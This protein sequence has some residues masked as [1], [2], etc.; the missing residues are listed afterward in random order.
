MASEEGLKKAEEFEQLLTRVATV[1]DE[2]YP[3]TEGF[4]QD[5]TQLLISIK[6]LQTNVAALATMHA[7]FITAAAKLFGPV[8]A[9]A[10]LMEVA[11]RDAMRKI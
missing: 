5:F 7:D 4:H 3:P 11:T 1:V 8:A 10:I 6:Q 2:D 9:G